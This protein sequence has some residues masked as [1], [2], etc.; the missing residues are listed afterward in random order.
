VRI[1]RDCELERHTTIVGDQFVDPRT[2]I[3]H[4]LSMELFIE[5]S[6]W[7]F[8]SSMPHF[9][10]EYTVRDL[11]SAE[12]RESTCV[13]HDFFEWAV[14]RIREDGEAV[15]WGGREFIYLEVDDH[16]YWS[17]GGPSEITTIINR[18]KLT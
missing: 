10:H 6:G 11:R 13:S 12:A 1:C 5:R 4:E 15:N 7:R 2:G 3:A 9:P 16:K 14:R 8:A 18:E 17:M